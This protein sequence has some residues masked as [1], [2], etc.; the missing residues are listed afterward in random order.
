MC[1]CLRVCGYVRACIE[2]VGQLDDRSPFCYAGQLYSKT[3]L[4]SW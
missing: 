4:V 2:D 3:Q 1:V